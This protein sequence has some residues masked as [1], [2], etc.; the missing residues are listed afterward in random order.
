M[1]SS[2]PELP[3]QPPPLLPAAP[4]DASDGSASPRPAQLNWLSGEERVDEEEDAAQ[5]S[6]RRSSYGSTPEQEYSRS[7]FAEV[8]W[9]ESRRCVLMLVGF[10]LAVV[11]LYIYPAWFGVRIVGD[12][13]SSEVPDDERRFFHHGWTAMLVIFFIE[14]VTVLLKVWSTRNTKWLANAVLQKLEGNIGVLIGEYLVVALTY[15]IMGANIFP[16]FEEPRT[17]RRV[18]GVRYMEWT[19]DV[20]GLVYLDCRILFGMKFAQFRMLLVYSALYMLLGLW[21]A[22]ASTWMLYAIFLGGSWF[23]FGVVCY[24]YWTYLRRNPGPLQQFGRAPIKHAILVFII[25][26]WILY[27][28]LFM[29]CFQAPGLVEQWLEQ[30]LWTAMDVVMKL[31]HCHVAY[32]STPVPHGR[33]LLSVAMPACPSPPPSLRSQGAY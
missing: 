26:W 3:G 19:V 32:G 28:V 7:R 22:L 27:G 6:R 2:E 4:D 30:L 13:D 17:G 11:H 15:I 1:S 23:F 14:G 24:Y 21:S 5:R 12:G 33:G 16:V 9:D 18:Y 10:A 8:A 25:I 20:C 31:S 29:V